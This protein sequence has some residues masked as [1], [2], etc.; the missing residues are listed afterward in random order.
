[1]TPEREINYHQSSARWRD[2]ELMGEAFEIFVGQRYYLQCVEIHSPHDPEPI[3]LLHIHDYGQL[4]NHSEIDNFT[5]IQ[6]KEISKKSPNFIFKDA[7]SAL[8]FAANF[9][10]NNLSR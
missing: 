9:A 6:H 1:M 3:F 8:N 10:R 4:N 5:D 7:E 2:L